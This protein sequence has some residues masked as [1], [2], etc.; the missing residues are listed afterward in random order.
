MIRTQILLTEEQAI[1]LR[2]LAAEEGRSM[3]ELIRQSV[4]VML[5]SRATIGREE[6]MCRALSVIGQFEGGALDLAREHDRYLEEAY[7]A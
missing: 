7:G 5:Q 1:A 3:A 6:R 2:E 4:D